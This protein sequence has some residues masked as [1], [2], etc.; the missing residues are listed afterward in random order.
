MCQPA[1]VSDPGPLSPLCVAEFVHS[2][3]FHCHSF[4]ASALPNPAFLLLPYWHHCYCEKVTF[5]FLLTMLLTVWGLSSPPRDDP[6]PPVLEAQS[7]NHW[8]IREVSKVTCIC[9]WWA[10][11]VAQLVKNLPAMRETWVRSLGWEDPLAKGKA[12]YSS[13]LAWRIPWAEEPGKL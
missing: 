6:M 12:T 3:S 8:T 13:V 11:L 7:L 1:S 4:P 5:F 10:S 2:Q 9:A